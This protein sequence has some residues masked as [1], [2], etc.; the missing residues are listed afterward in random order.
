MKKK[1]RAGDTSSVASSRRGGFGMSKKTNPGLNKQE[2]MVSSESL[3]SRADQQSIA[4]LR[5]QKVVANKLYQVLGSV[6]TNS[7]PSPT[8]PIKQ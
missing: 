8:S 1:S 3:E 5:A 7:S 4:S 6:N 2:S